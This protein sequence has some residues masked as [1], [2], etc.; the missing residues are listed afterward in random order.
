MN[1]SDIRTFARLWVN[2]PNG[3]RYSDSIVNNA[4]NIANERFAVD[5]KSLFKDATTTITV[6]DGTYSLPSDFMWEKEVEYDGK[7]LEAAKRYTIRNSSSDDDWTD[8][9]GAPTNYIID[10]EENRKEIRLYPIPDS[11][12]TGKSFT[13]VYF[14]KPSDLTADSSIPLNGDTYLYRFHMGV[15]AFAAWML[16]GYETAT[17]E[18]EAKMNRMWNLYRYYVDEA[19]D[20]YDNTVNEKMN[21]RGGRNYR[22]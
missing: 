8:D 19:L 3:T 22:P 2:D 17:P 15:A 14:A 6:D 4:I 7:P 9:K 13:L 10:P 5:S 20:T 11:S 18:T 16:M 12:Q 21:M 1:R